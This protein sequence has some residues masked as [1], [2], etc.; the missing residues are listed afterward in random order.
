[1]NIIC[2]YVKDVDECVKG[3]HDC[4]LNFATCVNIP[5][6]YNCV[7][8]HSYEGDNTCLP[9]GKYQ[10]FSTKFIFVPAS[11]CKDILY[12][13]CNTASPTKFFI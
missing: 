6:S 13:S 11:S 3:S 8:S 2:F 10:Y 5:G 9:E 4:F 7:C 12:F 1:M